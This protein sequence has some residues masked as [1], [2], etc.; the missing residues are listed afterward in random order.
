MWNNTNV[1]WPINFTMAP[2]MKFTSVSP[3][4]TVVRPLL[5][6]PGGLCCKTLILEPCKYDPVNTGGVGKG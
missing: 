2:I 5:Q 4:I 6:L 1:L 3:I